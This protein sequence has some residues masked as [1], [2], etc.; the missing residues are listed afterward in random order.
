MAGDVFLPRHLLLHSLMGY[1]SRRPPGTGRDFL[2]AP[3][4]PLP[5]AAVEIVEEIPGG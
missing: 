4:V 3:E 5:A 2:E 1:L